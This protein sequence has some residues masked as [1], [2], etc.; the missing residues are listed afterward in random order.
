MA[1]MAQLRRE[2][3]SNSFTICQKDHRFSKQSRVRSS[4]RTARRAGRFRDASHR[5]DATHAMGKPLKGPLTCTDDRPHRHRCEAARSEAGCR[6]D[7]VHGGAVHG[8]DAVGGANQLP[9][10]DGGEDRLLPLL[11]R[12]AQKVNA[13]YLVSRV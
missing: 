11:S 12:S 8:T 6:V 9:R 7:G 1:P 5:W 4:P 13:I 10:C 2:H 3:L